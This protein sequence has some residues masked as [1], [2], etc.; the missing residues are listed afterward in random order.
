MKFCYIPLLPLVYIGWAMVSEV[1]TT[2]G[3]VRPVHLSIHGGSLMK[4]HITCDIPC[5]TDGHWRGA[6]QGT[7]IA[8]DI[9]EVNMVPFSMEAYG[10]VRNENTLAVTNYDFSN[11]VH[12]TYWQIHPGNPEVEPLYDAPPV[13]FSTA[14]K[15]I[16]WIASNCGSQSGRESVVRKL[17]AQDLLHSKGSC[18]RNADAIHKDGTGGVNKKKEMRQYLFYA[19]FENKKTKDYVTEK[20]FEAFAAGTVPIV[21]GAPNM[22]ELVPKEWYI[23]ADDFD[24]TEE[25]AAYIQTVSQNETLYM[26][27]QHARMDRDNWPTWFV[28]KWTFRY[29]AECRLCKFVAAAREPQ[30]YTFDQTMQELVCAMIE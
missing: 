28:R 27:Y 11:E 3:G 19:A 21:Y 9:P 10:I 1:E 24:S 22:H 29:S 15:K 20:L 5:L 6:V 7:V 12:L 25:L 4:R 18:L 23:W 14:T 8:L 17:Q 13:N 2:C 26:Q 16:L 30:K